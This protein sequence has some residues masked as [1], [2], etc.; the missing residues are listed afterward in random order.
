VAENWN[1]RIITDWDEIYS[2]KFQDQWLQWSESAVNR[3]VFFHPALGMAW[4]ETY[5]PIRK[6]E[7]LFCIAE[8]DNGSFFLPLVLWHRNWK[9]AFQKIIIP[10]GYSDF[11]YHEPLFSGILNNEMWTGL[12]T[13]VFDKIKCSFTL[14]EI[15]INGILTP[16]VENGWSKETDVAPFCELSSFQNSGEFLQNLTTSLRGDIR[17]QIRRMEET[18]PIRLYQYTD[19][20]EA[21]NVLPELLKFHALRWPKAY[22][23]P[24]FH[25]NLLNRGLA[26][27]IVHFTSLQIGG[28]ALSYHLGFMHNRRYYYYMPVIDVQFENFS[29]GKIHLFKLVEYAIENGFRV[30]DHLRGDEN[31]KSGWAKD[32]Q[33]LYQYNW[34]SGKMISGIKNKVLSIKK[35]VF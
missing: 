11:D 18:G 12:Y 17:R 34:H 5:R 27:G 26:A 29:P 20:A 35:E 32:V 24:V 22:K 21:I 31:Y 30:F 15:Q 3:H 8:N 14:D 23:A 25:E 1:I 2:P 4:I 6:L 33:S 28:N 7:P 9:N 10:I 13:R 19:P 16:V